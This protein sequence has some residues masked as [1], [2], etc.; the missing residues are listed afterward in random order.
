MICAARPCGV[1]AGRRFSIIQAVCGTHLK[2][3]IYN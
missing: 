2:K 3:D 1:G